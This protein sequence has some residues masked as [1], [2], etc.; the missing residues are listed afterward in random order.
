MIDP[1][2]GF[3]NPFKTGSYQSTNGPIFREAS[4][5]EAMIRAYLS[6]G[7]R[8]YALDLIERCRQRAYPLA[9]ISKLERLIAI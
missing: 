1:P 4:T 9:L 3:A 5:Y 6:V 8:N 2:P 7:K